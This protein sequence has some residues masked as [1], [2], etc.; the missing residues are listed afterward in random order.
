MNNLEKRLH[1]RIFVLALVVF[2]AGTVITIDGVVKTLRFNSEPVNT[3]CL[4]GNVQSGT[5]IEISKYRVAGSFENSGYEYY[6]IEC[7][8]DMFFL[9]EVNRDSYYAKTLDSQNRNEITCQEYVIEGI[10]EKIDNNQVDGIRKD[11][12]DRGYD[13]REISSYGIFKIKILENEKTTMFF[14][15]LLVV[16]ALVCIVLN[17]CM[18][19]TKWK[20]NKA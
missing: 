17:G 19:K 12:F 7:S 9:I 16:L 6:I 5:R 11:L 4:Q 2:M 18:V 14:G 1:F 10:I 3:E 8:E 13:E 20:C 15:L